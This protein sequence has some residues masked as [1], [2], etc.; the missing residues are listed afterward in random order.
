M[1]A[2]KIKQ[3]HLELQTLKA[4]AKAS[5]DAAGSPEPE[6]QAAAK[7]KKWRC[8]GDYKRML[9]ESA[10]FDRYGGKTWLLCMLATGTIDRVMIAAVNTEVCD[11][12][13]RPR[14]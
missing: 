2:A 12:T 14:T 1:A 5:S 4:K 7:A 8:I 13:N 10:V 6:V 3:K 11:V 9:F